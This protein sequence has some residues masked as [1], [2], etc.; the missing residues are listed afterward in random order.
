MSI[1]SDGS[2]AIRVAAGPGIGWGHVVRCLAL[3]ELAM[4]TGAKPPSLIGP[5]EARAAQI[6]SDAGLFWVSVDGPAA[7]LAALQDCAI[8]GG[9]LVLDDYAMTPADAARL[10]TSVDCR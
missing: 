4:E 7:L 9:W 5:P 2:W 3:A 1:G 8:S 10:R 6:V